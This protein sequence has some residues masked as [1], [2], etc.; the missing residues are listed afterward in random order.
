V[1]IKADEVARQMID[2][3]TFQKS[4]EEKGFKFDIVQVSTVRE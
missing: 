4:L 1:K 3:A 2:V